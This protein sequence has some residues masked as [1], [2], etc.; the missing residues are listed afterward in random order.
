[1]FYLRPRGCALVPPTPYFR[2]PA[3]GEWGLE[4][5]EGRSAAQRGTVRHEIRI[6]SPKCSQNDSQSL[7]KRSLN[8]V[9]GRTLSLCETIG[10]TGVSAMF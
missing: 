7:P 6:K 10:F 5:L 4:A 1:M 8:A 2:S 9:P 3:G